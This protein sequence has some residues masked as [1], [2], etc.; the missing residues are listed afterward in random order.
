MSQYGAYGYAL[1][2]QDLRLH[3]RPLLH[4]HRRWA[5][6][7]P[8][9]RSGSCCR[10]P[11]S[12]SSFTGALERR[13]PEARPGRR[14]TAC[15]AAPA[16]L[17]LRDATGK[18]VGTVD[19]AAARRRARRPAAAPERH[20]GARRARRPAT[21]ARCSISAV[22]LGPRRG[23]R[24]RPRGLRARRGQRREPVGVAGR[25]AQGP[26]GRRAHLR[27]HDPRRRR[28]ASTSTPTRAR[29]ST[30]ASR[31]RRPAPTPPCAATRARSSPTAASRSPPTSSR[32]PAA[33]PRTS[34]TRSSARSPSRG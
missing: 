30:A 32:P 24:A 22:G 6:S 18:S 28:P 34:R 16:G 12:R 7:T 21:A 20:V 27:D 11:G 3:P 19:R 23:Q 29:R 8:T 5:R 14:P 10:A 33:R 2:L 17:V 4:G 26:G 15:A 31:P 13:R 9:P 1:H 25:G